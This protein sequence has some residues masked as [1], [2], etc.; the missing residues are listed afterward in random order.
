MI[1]G[2]C[3]TAGGG[4]TVLVI[5]I[6]AAEYASMRRGGLTLEVNAEEVDPRLPELRVVVVAGESDAEMID[7]LVGKIPLEGTPKGGE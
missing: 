6:T 7:Q 5:G 2:L 3:K 1:K 4:K